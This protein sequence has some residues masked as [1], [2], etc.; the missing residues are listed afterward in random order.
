MIRPVHRPCR[1]R[2]RMHVGHRRITYVAFCWLKTKGFYKIAGITTCVKMR[3]FFL[4]FAAALA[5]ASAFTT[6]PSAFS[7]VTERGLNNVFAESSSAHR[8]R[9]ATIVMDGKA[10]GTFYVISLL[11][12]ALTYALYHNTCPYNKFSLV[13]RSLL[14]Q[15]FATASRLCRI[16]RRSPWQ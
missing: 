7:S 11:P 14:K 4:W 5:T 15:L 13:F 16:P 10:N 2:I 12:F 8:T 1:K 3:L 9:K 6:A